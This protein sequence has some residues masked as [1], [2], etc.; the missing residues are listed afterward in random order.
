MQVLTNQINPVS[1]NC[2]LAHQVP[3]T[4]TMYANSVACFHRLPLQNF[5]PRLASKYGVKKYWQNNGQEAA[6]VN[7]VSAILTSP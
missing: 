1:V 2:L 4:M 3:D 5:W 6:I 7:A